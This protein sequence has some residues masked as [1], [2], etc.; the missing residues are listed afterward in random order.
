MYMNS[1]FLIFLLVSLNTSGMTP[2]IAGFGNGIAIRSVP[3]VIALSMLVD[4]KPPL[5]TVV[6]AILSF[7]KSM[8]GGGGGN[9]KIA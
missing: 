4:P 1:V 6:E 7:N 2:A 5:F 3:G 9:V 8:A